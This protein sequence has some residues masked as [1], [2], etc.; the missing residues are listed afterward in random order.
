MKTEAISND[1]Y[2]SIWNFFSSVK[3]TVVLLLSLAT[4]S[5]IGTF[6]PQNENP[7][8][9]IQAFGEFL[10]RIFHILDIFDMYQSWWFQLLLLLLTLNVL[11]CTIDRLSSTWKIIFVKTPHFNLSRFRRLKQKEEF[12]STHSIEQLETL[13]QPVLSQSFAYSRVE[14]TDTGFCIFSEKGR[15]TR[16]GVYAVHLSVILLLVGALIGSIF[17]FDGYI[18]I[19]EG[20]TINR[21]QLRNNNATFPLDFEVR[22]DDFDI[23][24][25]DSGMPSEYR[26]SLTVLEQGK[27]VLKKDI[28]VNDPLRYKG[29]N[30]YQSSYGKLEPKEITLNFE[31][32]ETGKRHQINVKFGRQFNLPEN[33][34]QFVVSD[35]KKS[36]NFR[37]QNIG[38]VFFGF[39]T[40]K[41]NDP[42]EVI[43]PVH[44]PEFDKMR[45]GN[46]VISVSG[47]KSRYYTG[48]QVTKDPGV[49]VVYSGFII[50]I[51]GCFITFFVSHQQ[52]CVDVVKKG[53]S[54]R[55]TL[56]GIS[57][58]NKLGMQNKVTII[59][60]KLHK[61]SGQ[62][63]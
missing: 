40:R 45:K 27:P 63:S 54:S 44:F 42:V 46:P 5:I 13:Y 28:I 18:N 48:L 10:Y 57:T 9:Y 4:T 17:G 43:L 32:T 12:K 59:S 58:K 33:M 7:A 29:I 2:N 60:E 21:I 55:V 56:S 47:Y 61:L 35:F 53:A 26:S 11:V 14:K 51:L 31:N 6:I 20:E 24:F 15:W 3:L 36:Y 37:G 25:Y 41:N 34:G 1:L 23:S 19:P 39:F 50:M 8:S 62:I 16:L 22:C 38:E 49:W 52:L 30:F